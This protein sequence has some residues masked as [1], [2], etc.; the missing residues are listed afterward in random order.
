M[1]NIEIS[2]ETIRLDQL[3]KLA[4]AVPTGGAVRSLLEDRRISV[5][6]IPE[7]ARRKK[8][9]PGDVVSLFTEDGE[10]KYKVV[11]GE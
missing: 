11:I 10:K 2:T 9:F 1:E 4:G 7:T 5:N 3:L 8:L 6:G